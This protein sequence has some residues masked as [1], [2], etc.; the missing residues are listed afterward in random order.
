MT[1]W[2]ISGVISFFLSPVE[3][4]KSGVRATYSIRL[5]LCHPE[6]STGGSRSSNFG[7]NLRGKSI[8]GQLFNAPSHPTNHPTNARRPS[9]YSL[10]P[11]PPF[12]S[13]DRHHLTQFL[14]SHI[15]P[16]YAALFCDDLQFVLIFNDLVFC[17]S[18]VFLLVLFLL[19]FL[20]TSFRL[21]F[22]SSPISSR[23]A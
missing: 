13:I 4:R 15:S 8:I 9:V 23:L 19:N 20:I 1:E 2:L 11:K 6:L 18:L 14:P 22:L 12:N 3:M 5:F 21:S 7:S 17:C 10:P 16:V